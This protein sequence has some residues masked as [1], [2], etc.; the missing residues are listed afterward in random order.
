V[1]TADACVDNSMRASDSWVD[2]DHSGASVKYSVPR[3]VPGCP[4]GTVIHLL[5]RVVLPNAPNHQV[6]YWA[7]EFPVWWRTAP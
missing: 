3:I 2:Y 5:A 4:P 6:K 1:F 7:L